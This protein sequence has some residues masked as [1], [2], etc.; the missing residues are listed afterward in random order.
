MFAKK[1]QVMIFAIFGAV[2][3][4]GTAFILY[5]S[6]GEQKNSSRREDAVSF[7]S[8]KNSAES[9]TQSCLFRVLDMALEELGENGGFAH[10]KEGLKV[11]YTEDYAFTF[12][13]INRTRM[14][15]DIRSI[16]EDIES[17]INENLGYCIDD[18]VVYER[19]NWDVR[20]PKVASKVVIGEK[21][22][23]VTLV[24]PAKF[25][26]KGASY[27]LGNFHARSDMKLKRILQNVNGII[28]DAE[29]A[30][31][32]LDGG[33]NPSPP[34]TKYTK[35][36]LLFLNHQYPGSGRFLWIIK[37]GKY[38]FFFAINLE[39]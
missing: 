14:L 12:L 9:F 33:G 32:V 5:I 15:P 13:Y 26:R 23:S 11:Q 16:E 27:E 7:A 25:I 21:D 4:I 18:F 3:L 31:S 38:E 10:R 1:G 30:Q 37:D 39:T 6:I 28:G 24:F 8:E 34:E 22:V 35:D 36:G 29:S 20:L 19:R 2:V 17:H